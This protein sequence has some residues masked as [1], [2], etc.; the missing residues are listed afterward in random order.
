MQIRLW[1]VRGSLPAPVTPDWARSRLEEVLSQFE[2][3]KNSDVPI[4]ARA[5]LDTLPAHLVGGYGGNTSCAEVTVGSSRLIIDAGSGLRNLS[6]LIMRTEPRVEEFHLFFTHFHWDHLI[7]LP[8]FVPMYVKGRT[9]HIYAVHDD[10]EET[11]ITLFKKPNFPVPY[12]TVQPQVRLHKV[13]PRKPFKVGDLEITPFQLDHPDP[14]W[15]ARVEANGKS[16]AWA[17]DSECTRTSREDLGEDVKLYQN[18]DLLVFDAQYSFGEA[19]EKINWGHS[20]APVG[21]DLA[22]REDVKLALFAHHDP[23]ASDDMVYQAEEQSR[24]YFD[25]LIRA[26]RKMGLPEPR[27]LWRFAR[28]G[29]IIQL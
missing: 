17:V 3:L 23:A 24:Q 28:E 25:E 22:I 14:C 29:E 7:G 19:L 2:R 21:I 8:F 27:L 9:V 12:S 16:L 6:D 26:R 13:A 18:A 11:L 1:G 5:F 15:G 10:L 20:S 4:N